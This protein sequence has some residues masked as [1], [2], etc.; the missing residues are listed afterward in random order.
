MYEVLT[1]FERAQKDLS[2]DYVDVMLFGTILYYSVQD[3]L[4]VIVAT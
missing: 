1:P 2:W 4:Y 3:V